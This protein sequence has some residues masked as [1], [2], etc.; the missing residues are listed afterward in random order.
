MKKA[1]TKPIGQILIEKKLITQEQLQKALEVQLQ[2]GGLVGQILVKLQFVTREQIEESIYEQTHRAQK[3]ENVLLEMGMLTQEQLDE[4][5]KLQET[6]GGALSQHSIDL[7][8]ISE[9]D[10]VSALVTQFGFPY[11]ELE[12]YEIDAELVK[13]VS[14]DIAVKYSLIPI[15]KIGNILTLAM[16]DPLNTSA[17][18][19]IKKMTELDVEAFISTFSD[20]NNAIAKYYA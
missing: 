2:E 6:K 16:A 18:D 3:L 1:R 15:D 9:E 14:K 4:A 7:G 17:K 13:L 12:N 19:Q 11:L 10:L 20:I 5:V 8:H